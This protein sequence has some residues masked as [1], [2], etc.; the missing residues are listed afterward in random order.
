MHSEHTLGEY[1]EVLRAAGVLRASYVSEVT[2]A[3]PITCVSYDSR[4]ITGAALFIVKGAHFKPAY[5]RDAIGAGAVAYV[6]EQAVPEET[7]PAILVTDIRQAIVTLGQ[8]YYDHVTEKLTSVGITGTK[9]K[10]TT[11]Y[12]L[13]E[14]LRQWLTAQA[15]AGKITAEA[16]RGPA[17]L[18]SIKNYA[19][20]IEEESHL[21]TPEPLELYAYFDQAYKAG[22]RHMVMEVSSQAL[23]YGRVAGMR[24]AVGAFTNISSDHISPIEHNDFEDYYRAKLHIFDY[25]DVVAVNTDAD[26]AA[27][28]LAY[29]LERTRIITYGSH[30]S[31]AVYC[32]PSS[33]APRK[34]GGYEFAVRSEAYGETRFEI[35]MPGQFNVSNALC[36]IAICGELGVPEHYVRAG[37][38]A[39][40]VPGRMEVFSSKDGEVT[41]IVD[42][43]HNKLSYEAVFSSTKSQY[44]DAEIIAIFGSAGNKAL[45]RRI[46][47]PQVASK[48]ASHIFITEDDSYDEPF[49]NIAADLAANTSA[50]Y[51]VEESRADCLKRAIFDWHKPRVI[52]ALG[53]GAETTHARHGVYVDTVNDAAMARQLIAQ[54]DA[55]A[56]L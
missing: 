53:K 46:D 31:A 33:L 37:L 18:S 1:I 51:T 17:I 14:I 44:P 56:Q 30:E 35:A 29:G 7:T 26:L 52:L 32:P 43:A 3:L 11:T 23:K 36:A 42:Y 45:E 20:G 50:P 55:A 12:Y 8:L 10:T 22:I 54:Y 2:A 24:F 19:G 27:R 9:G 15:A 48:Y 39:A 41:V 28:T 38:A 4:N 25:C 49:A 34:A 5:L 6:A 47:L 21:T 40:K 16:A 13:R